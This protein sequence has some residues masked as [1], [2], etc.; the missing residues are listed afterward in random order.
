MYD[1][2]EDLS[3]MYALE[4]KDMRG[5]CEEMLDL[6]NLPEGPFRKAYITELFAGDSDSPYKLWRY[7][8]DTCEPETESEEDDKDTSLKV[9]SAP[10]GEASPTTNMPDKVK[11]IQ[12]VLTTLYRNDMV[13]LQEEMFGKILQA[14]KDLETLLGM[15]K[16]EEKDC[17]SD[18][19][20]KSNPKNWNHCITCCRYTCDLGDKPEEGWEYDD[21]TEEW[22]CPDC[23]KERGGKKYLTCPNCCERKNDVEFKTDLGDGEGDVMVC[24]DCYNIFDSDN[25]DAGPGLLLYKDGTIKKW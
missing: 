13:W 24:E 14:R 1:R 8:Q 18:C 5:W 15:I 22:E 19:E 6:A 3:Q 25:E 7:I 10:A 17:S 11:I 16:K 23:F 21:E 4:L 2:K 20:C 9:D 12:S